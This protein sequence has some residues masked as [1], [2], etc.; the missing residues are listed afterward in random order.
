VVADDG[1][2]LGVLALQVPNER[3]Q[4]IMQFTAGMGRTGETYLVGQDHLMRSNSRF[5]EELTTL[6]TVVDSHTV[7]LALAHETG[8]DFTID[9]RGVRVLSAYGPFSLDGITWA[10]MAEIDRDEV[11]ESVSKLRLSI[12]ILGF[13]L[14]GLALISL[15]LFDSAGGSSIFESDTLDIGDLPQL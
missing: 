1:T 6:K 10:V 14:F 11:F 4:T 13:A 3:I 7:K 8:A 5:S 12:P 2:A 9:Y 15:W